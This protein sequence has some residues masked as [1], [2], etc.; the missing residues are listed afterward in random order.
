MRELKPSGII[1]SGGPGQRLRSRRAELRSGNLRPRHSRPRHLLRHA[2]RLPSAGGQGR[3]RQSPRIRPGP[4]AAS[5]KPIG[6]FAGVP[7]EMIVWMSHGDQVQ[8]LPSPSGR[9]AG[10]EGIHPPGL[11]RHLPRR[12]RP[13]SRQAGL[14]SAVSSRSQPHPVRQPDSAQFPLRDLRLH[15]PVEA[16]IVH[17]ANR[18]RHSPARR[19]ASR[20]LRPVRRRRFLRRGGAPHQG[21]RH[22]SRLH[23]RR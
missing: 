14:R 7:D 4:Y 2:A 16:R 21:H 3:R 11:D 10:G 22:P 20:H 1:F 17:R 5:M 13:A 23:L 18:R 6:L 15:R 19:H 12:R 8:M 9:G